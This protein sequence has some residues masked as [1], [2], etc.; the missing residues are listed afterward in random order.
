MQKEIKIAIITAVITS[1]IGIAG[2]VITSYIEG[3]KENQTGIQISNIAGDNNQ[4]IVNNGN[5]DDGK[6]NSNDDSQEAEV[7]L[8]T[9]SI[10]EITDLT[11][12]NAEVIDSSGVLRKNAIRFG[13]WN[14]NSITYD[15]DKKYDTLKCI[16]SLYKND[17]VGS[18]TLTIKADNEIVYTSK[19][20]QNTEPIEDVII[21]L[22]NCKYLNISS[23]TEDLYF[24]VIIS[25]AVVY[26][27]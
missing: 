12:N 10:V 4:V 11:T 22:D 8:V 26:N 6:Q 20:G 5:I 2:N 17:I 18:T 15:L 16:I 25:N 7:Y 19:L 24:S 23:D 14:H 13:T 21:P 1:V 3:K 27:E 9:Q